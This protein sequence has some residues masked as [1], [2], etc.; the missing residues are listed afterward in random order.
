VGSST[1]ISSVSHGKQE[2]PFAEEDAEVA[3]SGRPGEKQARLL[4]VLMTSRFLLSPLLLLLLPLAH[5]QEKTVKPSTPAVKTSNDPQLYRNSTFGF[6]YRIPY[7]WV[8]RTREMQEQDNQT[9]GKPQSEAGKG[10]D[11]KHETTKAN[12]SNGEVLLAVF[13]RP[14]EA[15]SDTVNSGVVIASESASSYP[16]LKGADDYL[17]QLDEITTAR[18]FKPDGD[19]QDVTIDSHP[20]VR[21]DFTKALN[22]KLTMYQSTLVRLEK[23]QIVSFTFIA[24][25]KDEIEDLMDGLSFSTNAERKR[26]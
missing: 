14:P 22:D 20:L 12:R 6:R 17:D 9:E 2:K 24:G 19:P 5:G 7:G 10:E 18:G 13:E 21:A 8:D 16:G 23:K 1:G 4:L 25:S 15:A 11:T 26:P 3:E